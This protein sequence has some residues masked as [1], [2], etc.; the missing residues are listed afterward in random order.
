[1]ACDDAQRTKFGLAP[2]DAVEPWI[3]RAAGVTGLAD[4]N[5]EDLILD[6]NGVK[7]ASCAAASVCTAVNGGANHI[8][9]PDGVADSSGKDSEPAMIEFL[10]EHPHP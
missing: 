8:R 5:I 9:W 6:A 2:K 3:D 7:V 1:M 4:V 10:R